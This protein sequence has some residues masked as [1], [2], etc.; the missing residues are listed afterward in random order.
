MKKIVLSALLMASASALAGGGYVNGAP[1]SRAAAPLSAPVTAPTGAATIPALPLTKT[2]AEGAAAAQVTPAQARRFLL[3][4]P[5]G[6]S[7][8]LRQLTRVTVELED[9]QASGHMKEQLSSEDIAEM[10][11]SFAQGVQAAQEEIE[12]TITVMSVGQVFPGGARELISSTRVP[13]LAEAGAEAPTIRVIQRVEP[14]GRIGKTRIE[15]SDP[16]M[17]ALFADFSEKELAEIGGNDN[18]LYGLPLVAGTSRTTTSTVDTQNLLGSQVVSAASMD[19]GATA[20][21][22]M[23]LLSSLKTSPLTLTNTVT[24]GGTDAQGQHLFRIIS[25]AQ[26]WQLA[27]NRDGQSFDLTVLDMTQNQTA[28]YRADGLP[29]SVSSDTAVR[30]RAKLSTTGKEAGS[31][32]MTFRMNIHME[33]EPQR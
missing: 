4:A 1:A 20:Q 8:T 32:T 7:V 22:V 2:A 23:E 29:Q 19:E 25:R 28:T 33:T 9:V 3:T 16:E 21:E 31:L 6:A 13:L 12:P 30:T 14:D 17:Q 5:S 27:L 24:Y 26:P 10:R 11:R 18:A 15:S